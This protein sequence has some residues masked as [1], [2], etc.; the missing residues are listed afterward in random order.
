MPKGETPPLSRRLTSNTSAK[1][2]APTAQSSLLLPSLLGATSPVGSRLHNETAF[3]CVAPN[4]SEGHVSFNV[5][6]MRLTWTGK[7]ASQ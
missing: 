5:G 4:A 3:S 6:V 2:H 7:A 1:R